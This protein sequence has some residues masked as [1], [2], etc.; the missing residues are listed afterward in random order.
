M[1]NKGNNKESKT[2]VQGLR[3]FGNTLPRGLKG[4]LK[5]SGFNYSEIIGK[6]G[7]LVGKE[8]SECSYPKSIKMK[9]GS[10]NGTLIIEIE[11]LHNFLKN[12][13][14]ERFYFDRPFYYS[15]NSINKLFRKVG[16]ILYDIEKIVCLL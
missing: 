12:L 2:Y 4:I 16:M 6:W 10:K 15:A 14:F 9:K 13:E 11:Y 8:I 3:A 1:H 5:K 7:N